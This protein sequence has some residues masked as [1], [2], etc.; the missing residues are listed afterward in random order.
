MQKKKVLV[1]GGTMFTGRMLTS[2]LQQQTDAELTLFNRGKTNPQPIA[3]VRQLHGNRESEAITQVTQD[4]WDIVVDFSGYYPD[5]FAQLL[6]QLRGKVKRYVFVSTLSVFDMNT[7]GTL[8]L[9]EQTPTLPCSA[10]ERT[11]RLPLAYGE[12]KA[13]MER[14]LLA[15]TEMET[16]IFR[17]SFIYGRYDWTQRFYYWLH[18]AKQGGDVLIPPAGTLSLTYADDLAR[19]LQFAVNNALPARVYNAVTHTGISLQQIVEEAAVQLGRQVNPV[20]ISEA[21][22]AMAGESY[23]PLALPFS[24]YAQGKLWQRDTKLHVTDFTRTVAE[25]IRYAKEL[26]WPVPACGPSAALQQEMKK[27]M[28]I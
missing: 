6:N 27:A 15:E 24:L 28:G 5:T 25:C 4:N 23:F 16:V 26:N 11:A 1:L 20:P 2:L 10:E 7:T 17:P 9:S 18:A 21:V 14:L 3:G 8:T 12:K 19:A 13:E 22:A